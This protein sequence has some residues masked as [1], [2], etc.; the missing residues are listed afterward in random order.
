M[1]VA[2]TLSR[3]CVLRD[4][5]TKFTEEIALLQTA[6]A[7]Q[8]TACRMVASDATLKPITAAAEDPS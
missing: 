7:E 8:M 2:D 4:A 5:E 3:A 1:I 6:D